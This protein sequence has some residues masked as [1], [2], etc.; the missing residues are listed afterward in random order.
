MFDSVFGLSTVA[1]YKLSRLSVL[2]IIHQSNRLRN[3]TQKACTS[4]IP[5]VSAFVYSTNILQHKVMRKICL[6][7]GNSIC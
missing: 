3:F 7:P 6:N 5:G 4:L 1:R 2:I